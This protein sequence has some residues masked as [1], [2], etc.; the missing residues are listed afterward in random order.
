MIEL[1]L[2]AGKAMLLLILNSPSLLTPF[3]A[4]RISAWSGLPASKDLRFISGGKPA[5]RSS[6]TASHG[7][8]SAH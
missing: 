8:C 1:P 2:N 6:A 4:K 3:C 7:A 5:S